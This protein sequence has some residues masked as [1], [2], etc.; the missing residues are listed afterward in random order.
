MLQFSN[1]YFAVFINVDDEI[2]KN[3]EIL[4]DDNEMDISTELTDAAS[5]K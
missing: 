5:T 3:L 2:A 1:I 4:S